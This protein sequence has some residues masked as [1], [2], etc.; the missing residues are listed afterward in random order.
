MI[1]PGNSHGSQGFFLY[2]RFCSSSIL[3]ELSEISLSVMA[4]ARF[5]RCSL[6][7]KLMAFYP[8]SPLD[9][10]THLPYDILCS[11]LLSPRLSMCI[12]FTFLLLEGS[13]PITFLLSEGISG[14]EVSMVLW[15]DILQLDHAPIHGGG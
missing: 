10:S 13:R 7:I 15:A 1:S 14:L 3:C 8:L 2:F 6:S 9:I 12:Y 4:L 11:R 5:I